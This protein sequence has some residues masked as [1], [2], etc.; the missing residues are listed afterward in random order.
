MTT[1]LHLSD[2]HLDGGEA[3]A[4]RLRA[5]LDLMPA[6]RRPDAVVITGDVADRGTA[7]EYAQFR[8]VMAHRGPWIAVPGNHDDPALL[9]SGGPVATLANAGPVVTLDAGGLRIVGLDTTV[10]GEDH[11]L[12]RPETA[13]LAAERAAGAAATVLAFH[14][15]PVT[16]GHGYIDPMNLRNPDALAGLV[17]RIGTVAAILCGHAHTAGA[18][19]FAGVPLLL[20]PG[21]V[22]SL[23]TDPD[24]R[25][26]TNRALPPGAA[27]HRFDRGAVTTTFHYAG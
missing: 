10:P 7:P 25:P 12:L 23:R 26:L 21:I 4:D 22:S 9:G 2:P 27:L 13:D 14:Q 3:R 8:D 20:A 16:I 15:P 19:A 5:V 11:G 6:S 1:L 17:A 24:H 18:A